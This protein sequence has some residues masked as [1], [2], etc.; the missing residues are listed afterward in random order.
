MADSASLS[1]ELA[2]RY[3][4]ALYELSEEAGLLETVERDLLSLR[5]ALADSAE[6]SDVI[7]SPVYTRAEQQSAMGAVADAMGLEGLTK[8][9]LK[10]M[11]S[12]RRL[13]ALPGVIGAYAEKM[14]AY[15]GEVSAEVT[16]AVPMRDDQLQA[17]SEALSA[18]VGKSVN[19]NVTVD[20]AII[21]GLVVKVGSK[22][23][24]TSIATKLSKLNNAMKEVG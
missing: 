18:A 6:L 4:T 22:M 17:L 15:R 11:A 3:A 20:E 14:A 2:G 19:V 9:T 12:K 24:D 8:N 5:Q 16:S 21:G 23:I 13:F 1:S 7:A 10:L